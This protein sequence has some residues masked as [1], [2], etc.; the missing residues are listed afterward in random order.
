MLYKLQCIWH[1]RTQISGCSRWNLILNYYCNYVIKRDIG[2]RSPLHLLDC[3]GL[4][5]SRRQELSDGHSTPE[6]SM[7]PSPAPESGALA[8]AHR[9]GSASVAAAHSSRPRGAPPR[10]TIA[11]A[12][13]ASPR[14]PLPRRF[15]THRLHV[16]GQGRQQQPPMFFRSPDRDSKAASASF[17]AGGRYRTCAAVRVGGLVRGRYRRRPPRPP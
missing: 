4:L 9:H 3:A 8:P 15:P 16:A 6:T 14:R 13:P 7:T 17:G 11:S 2:A 12:P 5:V 10:A 1:M